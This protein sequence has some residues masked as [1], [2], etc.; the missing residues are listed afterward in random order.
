M[1]PTTATTFPRITLDKFSRYTS[2]ELEEICEFNPDMEVELHKHEG[3]KYLKIRNV[4]KRP[5]DLA[6][7][8]SKFPC[9]DRNKSIELGQSSNV[10]SKAPGFQQ[11]IDDIYLTKLNQQVAKVGVK[12]NLFKYNLNDIKFRNYTNCCYPN[13]KAIGKNYMPHV[14][15]FSIAANFYLTDVKNTGT[16]FYKI[17]TK[18]KPIYT[19]TDLSRRLKEPEI[20]AAYDEIISS[21]SFPPTCLTQEKYD[22]LMLE[23]DVVEDWIHWTGNHIWTRYLYIPAE[24]NSCLMYRGNIWHTITYDPTVEDVRYSL[25]SVIR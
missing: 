20:K 4:L 6:E 12:N 7:F 19:D 15:F 22:E 23:D 3:G 11:P 5:D 1:L 25:V 10:K 13:M 14:D 17:E 24:Y 9:Q 8:C 16:S 2:R 21:K 18:T